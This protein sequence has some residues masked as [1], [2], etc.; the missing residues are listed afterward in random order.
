MDRSEATALLR[1]AGLR[2]TAPRVSVLLELAQ[3]PHA[4]IETLRSRVALRLGSVSAQTIYDVLHAF[5]AS[6]LVRRIDPA[7]GR[8]RF[9]LDPGNGHHHLVCRRCASVV[10]V[11]PDQ[12]D[13]PPVPADTHGFL[14]ETTEVQYLGLCPACR[15][16]PSRHPTA[17]NA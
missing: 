11:A 5:V 3:L 15:E 2:V 17:H 4:D 7:G 13:T 14:V 8:A 12:V 6:G 1:Q 10:D 9:E 16:P